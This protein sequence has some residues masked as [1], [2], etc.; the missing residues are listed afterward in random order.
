MRSVQNSKK[1]GT[2]QRERDGA[3]KTSREKVKGDGQTLDG[4]NRRAGIRHRRYKHHLAPKIPWRN[5]PRSE[6]SSAA[7]E[8][9]KARR[10]SF[11]TI[12][13]GAPVS[14]REEDQS[15]SEAASGGGGQSLSTAVNIGGLFAPAE[16]GSAAFLGAGATADLVCFRR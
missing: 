13:A 4:F 7:P 9:S 8:A 5:V 1:Q 12:F 15:V 14:P 16:S 3:P 11:A 10:I 2:G 6:I